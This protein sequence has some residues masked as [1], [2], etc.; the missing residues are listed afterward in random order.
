MV[1]KILDDYGVATAQFQLTIDDGE[2]RFVGFAAA[3]GGR[4]EL[5]VDEALEVR[6]LE[7]KS[8]QK[9]LVGA[10]ASDAF[11]L[12][13]GDKPHTAG[14]E[15]FQLDVVVARGA[16][17]DARIA[18]A[19]SAATVRD[20]HFGSHRDARIADRRRVG[21]GR[22]QNAGAGAEKPAADKPADE[23]Q[24]EAGEP[25]LAQARVER[26]RQNSEKNAQEILGIAGSFDE[27]RE[28]LINNRVDTP[29]LLTRLKD[30]IADPLRNAG[31]Q[32]FPELD[33]RL[34][35]L[36]EQS[37]DASAGSAARRQVLEQLDAILVELARVRDKMLELES[38]NEAIDMLR[39]I[40]DA[41]KSL[42]QQVRERQKRKVRDLLED[43]P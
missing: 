2:P 11:H 31:E 21:R 24:V 37:K 32:M 6:E 17:C 38:F 28:E 42:Q 23:K 40:I 15:R 33:V 3:P 5:D 13:E 16:A 34:K 36:L 41:E 1:G 29:E 8:G 20:S 9:L 4:T 27:I 35:R 12:V 22:G 25:S 43:S 10:T 30:N 18:R 7:L 39:S 26:G 14:S 19:E